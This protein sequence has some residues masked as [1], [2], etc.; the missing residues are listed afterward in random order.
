[1]GDTLRAA[2]PRQNALLSPRDRHL[3]DPSA[4]YKIATAA[5]PQQAHN[6]V[7][8]D[9]TAAAAAQSGGRGDTAEVRGSP[10]CHGASNRNGF[11]EDL[12]AS[13]CKDVCFY[14]S[15]KAAHKSWHALQETKLHNIHV[16]SFQLD[17]Q[18]RRDIDMLKAYAFTSPL[19]IQ[20]PYS[21]AL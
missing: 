10:V 6:G 9:V 18:S 17:E 7:P 13:G 20:R 16:P 2:T 4:P 5:G 21:S 3:L 8:I 14:N 1:M 19:H 12:K 11:S 15:R